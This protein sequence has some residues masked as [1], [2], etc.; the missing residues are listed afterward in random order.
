[1]K[2]MFYSK[3]VRCSSRDWI[4]ICSTLHLVFFSND[5]TENPPQLPK[6]TNYAKSIPNAQMSKFIRQDKSQRKH[7]VNSSSSSILKAPVVA[8]SIKERPDWKGPGFVKKVSKKKDAPLQS[9]AKAPSD[10]KAQQQCLPVELQQL[11]LDIFRTSF[12]A[13][14]DYDS[15]K[16]VLQEVR[17][18]L[19]ERDFERAFG[20]RE[21]REAFVVR[22]CPNRA[23]LF[24]HVIL[25]I[26]EGFSEEPWI[27][28]LCGVNKELK[29]DEEGRRE[30]LSSNVVCFGSGPAELMALAAVL[31]HIQPSSR[32]Y[33]QLISETLSH[34]STPE[35]PVC[36]SPT[37]QMHILN[38]SPW[39]SAI[40]ALT[41][42]LITP[43]ILSKYASATAKANNVSFLRQGCME[44]TFHEI[45]I[46]EASQEILS[47]TLGSKPV[48]ITICYTLN[49]LH[50]SSVAKTA[51][52][53]LKLTIVAPKNSLLLVIDSPEA[54]LEAAA[55]RGPK[56]S[57]NKGKSRYSMQYLMDL[58]LLE[59]GLGK[60]EGE[61]PAWEKLVGDGSRIF[62]L[63]ER[64][65]YPISLENMRAQVYLFRRQ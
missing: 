56:V 63:D 55:S 53:L 8:A 14:Q 11:V 30:V 20:K 45:S 43:P 31:R 3:I 46:L 13:C 37:P 32:G 23:L 1:M 50:M 4:F 62:K 24:A 38:A 26:C 6:Q 33:P 19:E 57:E 51:A 35:P 22:W 52:F 64:L 44:T 25:G 28:S 49:D 58:V 59:K 41:S 27:R 9:I 15:L 48:L 16:L 39:S 12:P 2:L 7:P 10:L 29:D 42:T 34:A 54:D 61:E 5:N 21:C 65:K 18:A 40:N 17:E 36:R 47:S 60:S